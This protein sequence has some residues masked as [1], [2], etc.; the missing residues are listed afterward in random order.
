MTNNNNNNERFRWQASSVSI[1][2]GFATGDVKPNKAQ[3]FYFI[4][5]WFVKITFAYFRYVLLESF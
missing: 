4:I 3:R 1:L 2:E 5:F